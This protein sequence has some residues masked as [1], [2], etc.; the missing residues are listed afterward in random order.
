[1]S[2]WDKVRDK[3]EQTDTGDDHDEGDLWLY[4]STL[5][6]PAR[7]AFLDAYYGTLTDEERSSER[8]MSPVLLGMWRKVL[9]TENP[10]PGDLKR[11]FKF[12]LNRTPQFVERHFK[13]TIDVPLF[14]F[15]APEVEG[16]TV[17][18]QTSSSQASS[19]TWRVSLGMAS[20]STKKVQVSLA[21]AFYATSG[22]HK[23]VFVPMDA[24]ATRL[25]D[26]DGNWANCAGTLAPHTPNHGFYHIRLLSPKS[27]FLV[28]SV[29]SI[30]PPQQ[31]GPSTK[32][33]NYRL[34]MDLTGARADYEYIYE[35]TTGYDVTAGGR[36]H[37]VGFGTTT[38]VAITKR[39][40]I[41]LSLVGGHNYQLM[42][43][44][45]RPG[46]YWA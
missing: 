37:G 12:A 43:M 42:A 4:A 35:A 6:S 13:T 28:P 14:D 23:R 20:Q 22:E 25:Y 21:A 44:T 3:L 45:D 34:A 26:L 29:R 11:V 31:V 30:D 27:R 19:A 41:K 5:D 8:E 38:N 17:S 1:M 46:I 7:E 33:G 40:A 32:L 16:C 39:L 15:S 10:S 24:V 2:W 18:V 36:L 9:S